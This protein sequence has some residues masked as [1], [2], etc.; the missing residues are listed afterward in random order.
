MRRDDIRDRI[1][2]GMGIAA[3]RLGGRC[4]LY[5]PTGPGQPIVPDNRV[6]QLPASFN[7]QNPSYAKPNGYGRAVWFGVFDSAYTRSGDYLAGD[8]GV[9]FVAAQQP[10]LPVLCVRTDRTVSISRPGGAAA[11]GVNPYGGV[12][13]ATLQPVISG[14]RVAIQAYRGGE[15]GP[16][17]SDPRIPFWMLLLPLLPVPLQTADL[18]NDD[19]GR[20]FMISAAEQSELGWRCIIQQMAT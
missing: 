20:T 2:R 15:A 3:K 18:V 17:P 10:L 5:R 19:L 8:E 7:A 11:S 9:F 12:T 16:L 14:W 6:L 1:S 13:A 4:D